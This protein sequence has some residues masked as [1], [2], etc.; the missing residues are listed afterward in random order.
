MMEKGSTRLKFAFRDAVERQDY[1][2]LKLLMTNS[3]GAAQI[4]KIIAE[5]EFDGFTALQRACLVQNKEMVTLF[6]DHGVEIDHRGKYGWTALHAAS[7]ACKPENDISIVLLLL[8]SCANITARDD[9]GCLPI[10]LA[11]NRNVKD[12][13][14]MRM[15]EK[16]HSELVDM[17]RKLKCPRTS[18]KYD[19]VMK[20]VEEGTRVAA[21]RENKENKKEQ[22][23]RSKSFSVRS[24][25][26][27]YF[28]TTCEQRE[29]FLSD[30][31][32]FRRDRE[33]GKKRIASWNIKSKR[34]SG[35]SLDN[36]DSF[37]YV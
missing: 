19:I 29:Q 6:V 37:T 2:T 35:I 32:V 12:A 14:L 13:L 8:N 23:H 26:S 17:Y 4:R 31:P 34:D 10:D 18:A 7:F 21:E 24:M 9:H 36:S 3:V 25:G 15:D 28:Y 5:E 27:S 22:S 1:T 16:G 20:W 30:K 33:L 11:E